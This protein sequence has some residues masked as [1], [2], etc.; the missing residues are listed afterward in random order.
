MTEL[1]LLWM[2]N[3][4]ELTEGEH[5]AREA[6][7][8]QG[9]RYRISRHHYVNALDCSTLVS[10]AHWIGA[11]I[12]MPF[13]ADNQRR[14]AGAVEVA[15]GEVQAGDAL[16][17][18]TSPA[19]SPGG[20]FNHVALCLG[21]DLDGQSW[22]IESSDPVGVRVLRGDSIKTSGGI[23][24]FAPNQLARF[25]DGDWRDVARAVP[26]LGRLG[27][28]LTAGYDRSL[29][30]SH[31]GWDLFAR[32]GSSIF[33][34]VDGE[35]EK[36]EK[37]DGYVVLSIWDTVNRRYHRLS[38]IYDMSVSQGLAVAAGAELGALGRISPGTCNVLPR[39]R[40]V[41]HLHWEL[42][43]ERPV[44]R[45]VMSASC[46]PV[47]RGEPSLELY[48]D[49]P[50]YALKLRSVASPL[51]KLVLVPQDGIRWA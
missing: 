21:N 9:M 49:N 8:F 33:S 13:I 25:A 29:R 35:V 4:L 37:R 10:Q 24:R 41:A 42:W 11:G 38:P 32:E 20:R 34:P 51:D 7:T 17:S 12:H 15:P 31:P 46:T 45:C 22:G 14:A 27:A 6:L 50:I 43:A 30:R 23:R 44:S 3:G 47:L 36:V 2:N 48:P 39:G 19:D 18:Y 16:Y 1:S 28:R 40:G 5:I 26:K